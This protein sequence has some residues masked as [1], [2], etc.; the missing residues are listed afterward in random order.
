[1]IGLGKSSRRWRLGRTSRKAMRYVLLFWL[2][3][4]FVVLFPGGGLSIMQG[5]FVQ[6]RAHKLLAEAK[7]PE[8]A[9]ELV[10]PLG[11]FF[12]LADGSWIAIHYRDRHGLLSYSCATIRDSRGRWFYSTRHFCGRFA[13]YRQREAELKKSP[14]GQAQTEDA[15]RQLKR[16]D[17]ELF[18]L[19][20]SPTL[21]SAGTQLFQLGFTEQ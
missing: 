10:G 6:Q 20:T 12:T 15:S 2:L 16:L 9:R 14:Q 1:M 18:S 11:A 19:A 5:R 13:A 21:E 8:A 4:L 7:T 3:A 17:P